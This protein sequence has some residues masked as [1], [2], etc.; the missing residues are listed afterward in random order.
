MIFYFPN[1]FFS[2]LQTFSKNCHVLDTH[3]MKNPVQKEYIRCHGLLPKDRTKLPMAILRTV[4][5]E[6]CIHNNDQQHKKWH[7][8]VRCH[9]RKKV[10]AMAV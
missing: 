9:C 4:K 10:I 7:K 3:F 5:G 8:Y 6:N 1:I 2:K